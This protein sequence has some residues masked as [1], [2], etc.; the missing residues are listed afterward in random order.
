MSGHI[1]RLELGRSVLCAGCG[2]PVGPGYSVE[3]FASKLNVTRSDGKEVTAGLCLECS[4]PKRLPR[5]MRQ[6][7]KRLSGSTWQR[8][9]VRP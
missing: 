1:I 3:S 6:A 7:S 8:Y 2:M 5:A 9:E 4:K